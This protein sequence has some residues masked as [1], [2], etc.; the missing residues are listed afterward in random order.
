[1]TLSCTWH[2]MSKLLSTTQGSIWKT[3][4]DQWQILRFGYVFEVYKKLKPGSIIP[5]LYYAYE[6]NIQ[7]RHVDTENIFQ[8]PTLKCKILKENCRVKVSYRP[9]WT[10][11]TRNKSCNE[12]DDRP[13][14]DMILKGIQRW[15]MAQA[16]FITRTL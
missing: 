2:Q 9:K 16:A 15:D 3:L 7:G 13:Y 1:M 4:Y 5:R 12:G 6:R 10:W 14:P 8:I 11:R